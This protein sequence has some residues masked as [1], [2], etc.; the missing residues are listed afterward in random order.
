MISLLL[1]T[2][3]LA[4]A[5]Q[6]RQL[7]TFRQTY[8]PEAY[9]G[10]GDAAPPPMLTFIMAGL[11]GFRG[12]ISEVLWFRTHRLQEEGR[13]IELVQLADWITMLDPHAVESW[14]YNA[15]NM[16]YNISFMMVRPEDRLRWVQSGIS[17]LRDEGLRFNPR[18]ERLYRELA[19][20]YQNKI[21]D[22]LDSAHLTY[23]LD[24]A[25]SMAPLLNT[26]GTVHDSIPNRQALAE[27][28]L[29]I[30]RMQALE[31]TFG[32]LDWRVA[33]SHAIYWASLSL[34]YARGTE[35]LASRRALYQP[36]IH[37]VLNGRFTGDLAQNLWRTTGNPAFAISAADFMAD[38]L[39]EFPSKN[40]RSVY[41][42]YLTTTIK[43]LADSEEN[44]EFYNTLLFNRLV[45]EL[46]E[47]GRGLTLQDVLRERL[48]IK[49]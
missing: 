6:T 12:V 39:K 30:E 25:Q 18:N 22:D 37:C 26:N 21:G 31:T 1:G 45:R 34:E 15:W 32:P 36:L 11:G 2:L 17:L 43:L 3:V 10:R 7:A 28:G 24:L 9:T 48:I 16:A 19:W 23:K 8:M 33:P 29:D 27:R 41:L 35:R 13:Y 42:N 14:I 49:D 40:M 4:G 5:W 47:K 20:I 46:G 44:I 38:T